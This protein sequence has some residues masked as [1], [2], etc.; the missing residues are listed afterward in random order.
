MTYA[1]F[2][3]RDERNWGSFAEKYLAIAFDDVTLLRELKTK[4]NYSPKNLNQVHDDAVSL[5]PGV[6]ILKKNIDLFEDHLSTSLAFLRLN[7][8][9]NEDFAREAFS[10]ELMNTSAEITGDYE[11]AIGNLG[12]DSME[13]LKETPEL[14]KIFLEQVALFDKET[15]WA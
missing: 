10:F 14:F 2:R 4:C 3:K 8:L 9:E 11:H 5:A 12:F 7:L 6:F 15:T 13:E 1:E